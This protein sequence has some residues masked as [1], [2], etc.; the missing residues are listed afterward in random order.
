M[1][2]NDEFPKSVGFIDLL[3]EEISVQT[4]KDK[5]LFDTNKSQ[6]IMNEFYSWLKRKQPKNISFMDWLLLNKKIQNRKGIEILLKTKSSDSLII[7]FNNKI[8]QRLE[9]ELTNISS[10]Y[11]M[12][13]NEQIINKAY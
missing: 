5:K 9:E 11:K 1:Y 6:R 3:T 13:W 8:F 10:R 12:V 4:D 7:G 2:L